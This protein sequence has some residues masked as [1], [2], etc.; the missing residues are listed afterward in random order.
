MQKN[1]AVGFS[2]G[3]DSACLL[4]IL[5]TNEKFRHRVF[6]IHVNHNLY[7]KSNEWQDFV[8]KFCHSLNIKCIVN[9]VKMAALQNGIEDAARNARYQA[10]E[11]SVDSNTVLLL[12][13][14]LNDQIE[15]MLHRL[16]LGHGIQG[17]VGM[18]YIRQHKHFNILRPLLNVDKKLILDYLGE[19]KLDYINDPSNNDLTFTRNWIRH[20]LIPTISTKFP[21]FINC[22]E[23]S[24]AQLKMAY[25]L[26]NQL[27]SID[28]NEIYITQSNTIN[29][30]KFNLLTYERRINCL[31][32]WLK[33][34]NLL[35]LSYK[36]INELVWQLYNIQA[37][38][39]PECKGNNYCFKAYNFELFLIITTDKQLVS[40][41]IEFKDNECKL[42]NNGSLILSNTNKLSLDLKDLYVV[43]PTKLNM[44]IYFPN[45][46]NKLL[47]KIL[48]ELK[49][50][51]WERYNYPLIYK[52]KKLFYLPNFGN[53]EK[54]NNSYIIKWVL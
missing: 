43:Y 3:S 22:M 47:K 23:K 5:A 31:R 28:F 29:L 37:G 13:H 14:H 17:I 49:I 40:K 50:P 6:A 41:K 20:N 21:A 18:D 1:L 48:H 46:Q 36:K 33:I 38:S 39:H 51:P 9:N 30:K 4:H 16:L 53:V 10:F 42:D 26:N 15:T 34:N 35:Q 11:N 2:G 25:S 8:Y 45:K 7:A 44:K 27:A 19:Y 52:D 24:R 12:A 54:N 32:Y